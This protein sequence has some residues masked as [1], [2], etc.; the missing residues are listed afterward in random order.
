MRRVSRLVLRHR[1]VLSAVCVALAVWLALAQLSADPPGQRVVVAA[2]DLASGHV[3]TAADLRTSVTTRRPSGAARDTDALVGRTVAAPMRAGEAFTDVRLAGPDLLAA[4]G[5]GTVLATV[6][7]ADPESLA[8]LAVGD[9]AVVVAAD[10]HDEA[11]SRVVTREARIVSL[12]P[13]RDGAVVVGLGVDERTAL[14][15]SAASLRG[16][17][18]LLAVG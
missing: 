11:G 4:L 15:I 5:E 16:P 2:D 10:P 8:A 7:V 1:R 9:E 3:L 18:S 17:L 13:P 12:P 14:A 6:R